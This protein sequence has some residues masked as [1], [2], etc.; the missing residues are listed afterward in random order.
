[1]KGLLEQWLQIGGS[2]VAV[3]Q[4]LTR[5]VN[6]QNVWIFVGRYSEIISPQFVILGE[7]DEVI[8][9]IRGEV[10]AHSTLDD[11]ADQAWRLLK[12]GNLIG[13]K[14]R[15]CGIVLNGFDPFAAGWP[16]IFAEAG[17]EHCRVAAQSIGEH[18]AVTAEG[19]TGGGGKRLAVAVDAGV[20]GRCN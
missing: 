16:H 13:G 5:S 19:L 11:S 7:D 8:L 18:D 4:N 6:E 10:F 3:P 2:A 9:L 15:Q 17:N 1:M 20:G 12:H 14:S